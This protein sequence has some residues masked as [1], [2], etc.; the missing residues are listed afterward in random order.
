M[1]TWAVVNKLSTVLEEFKSQ[2]LIQDAHIHADS[3]EEYTWEEVA[4]SRE[5]YLLLSL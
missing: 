4:A 1:L 5:G 3:N 2:M